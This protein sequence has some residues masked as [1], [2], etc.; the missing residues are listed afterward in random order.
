MNCGSCACNVIP[1]EA[2]YEISDEPSTHS[3]TSMEKK[4][5][6]EKTHLK[7]IARREEYEGEW[8]RLKKHTIKLPRVSF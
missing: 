2:V 8:K 3:A 1:R 7:D 6:P 4:I 5:D